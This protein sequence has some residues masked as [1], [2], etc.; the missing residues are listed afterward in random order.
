M[1]PTNEHTAAMI[2]VNRFIV[3]VYASYIV[4]ASCWLQL[5][6]V[7]KFLLPVG[8]VFGHPFVERFPVRV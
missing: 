8:D 1:L 6:V 4:F 2:T 3:I 7:V 5:F